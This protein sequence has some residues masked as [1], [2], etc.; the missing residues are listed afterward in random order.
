VGVSYYHQ[1][2]YSSNDNFNPAISWQ[3]GYDLVNLNGEWNGI[4]GSGAD[5][6]VFVN[7]VFENE[8]TTQVLG[9]GAATINSATP[10]EPR[11]W[12]VRLRYRLG[13]Q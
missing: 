8:Y 6:L 3:E 4:F 1:D 2:R 12:G 7:N 5:L 13:A 9:I 10:A 11:V